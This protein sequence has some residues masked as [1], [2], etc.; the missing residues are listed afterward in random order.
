MATLNV[1]MKVNRAITGATTVSANAFAIV[2]FDPVANQTGSIGN[3]NS[4]TSMVSIT[5]FYGPLQSIP[6]SIS[7]FNGNQF[8]S[9]GAILGTVSTTYS[10]RSGV[11]IINTI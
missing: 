10:L 5:R 1:G 7:I 11:E 9:G 3:A 8:G 4:P 6:S 2:T